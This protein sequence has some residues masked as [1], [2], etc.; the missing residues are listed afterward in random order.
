MLI[1]RELHLATRYLRHFIFVPDL[2]D[3]PRESN[4]RFSSETQLNIVSKID[5]ENRKTVVLTSYIQNA[6]RLAKAQVGDPRIVWSRVKLTANP[7]P[8]PYFDPVPFLYVDVEYDP[9][10][11]LDLAGDKDEIGTLYVDLAKQALSKLENFDGFPV[12]I[13]LG[14]YDQFVA[15]GHQF[16][17]RAGE[18]MLPGTKLKGGVTVVVSAVHTIRYFTLHYRN[19]EILRHAISESEGGEMDLSQNFSGFDLN[20]T[21]ATIR[22][23]GFEPIF[24]RELVPSIEVDLAIYPEVTALMSKHGWNG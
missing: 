8:L 22:G 2:S 12:D 15:A 11:F 10:N 18:A 14:A 19:K 23:S 3:I 9:R 16:P 6:L 20:G 7:K 4:G 5:G 1:E 24:N 17:V 21:I 13:I